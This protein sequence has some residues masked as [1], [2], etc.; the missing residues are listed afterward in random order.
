M[1]CRAIQYRGGRPILGLLA[2]SLL[3]GCGTPSLGRR[4]EH[5]LSRRRQRLVDLQSG[6]TDISAA[7]R[8]HYGHG[9]GGAAAM[10]AFAGIVGTI[11]GRSASPR[12]PRQ[13]N[14]S[15]LLSK[16]GFRAGI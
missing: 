9:G 12:R 5:R 16:P 2:A 4:C 8:R 1:L 11:G 7:R 13:G 15:V 14:D 6:N 10:A 3:A